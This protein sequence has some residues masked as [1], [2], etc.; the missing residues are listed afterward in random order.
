MKHWGSDIIHGLFVDDMI[1]I[2]SFDE[3]KVNLRMNKYIALWK[4]DFEI[5]GDWQIE[6]LIEYG[7]NQVIEQTEQIVKI[8]LEHY[9]KEAVVFYS[10]CTQKALR[11]AHQKICW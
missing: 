9:V 6:T 11:S 2:Y 1:H 7:N 10:E 4:R 5:K 3:V 8:N